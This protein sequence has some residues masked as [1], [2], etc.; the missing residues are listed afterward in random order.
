[1][2]TCVHVYAYMCV[3]MY[4]YVSTCVCV[5]VCGMWVWLC[6][7]VFL[8]LCVQLRMC[9]CVSANV[10]LTRARVRGSWRKLVLVL[11]LPYGDRSGQ[12]RPLTPWCPDCRTRWQARVSPH[13]WA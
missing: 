2:C 9:M 3:S 1:M 7:W 12:K 13:P 10:C 6:A 4:V 8:C 11:L 5:Y